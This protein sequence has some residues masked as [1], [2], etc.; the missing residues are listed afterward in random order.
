M[1]AGPACVAF[2]NQFLRTPEPRFDTESY[3]T[4]SVF[5]YFPDLS[6][7]FSNWWQLQDNTPSNVRGHIG[8]P[9]AI[10][11]HIFHPADTSQPSTPFKEK[12]DEPAPPLKLQPKAQ[13]AQRSTTPAEAREEGD[14]E[15]LPQP[16]VPYAPRNADE[17]LDEQ[18]VAISP[19]WSSFD[20][21]KALRNLRSSNQAIIVRQLRILHLRWWHAKSNKMKTILETAGLPKAILD[22]I[23]GVIDTCKVCRLWQRPG[24]SAISSSRLSIEFNHNVQADLLFIGVL[25]I[26]HMICEATRW[27]V[28]VLLEGKKSEHIMPAI[29]NCWFRIWGPPETITA[30][31]EGALCSEEASIAFE[32]WGV[33][34]RPKPVGSHAYVVERHHELLRSQFLHI[35]QQ[36]VVEKLQVSDSEILS[37]ATFAKNTMLQIHGKSPYEAVIGRTPK[38]MQEFEDQ[39]ISAIEDSKGGSLSRHAVRLREV[40][41]QAML[42]GTAQDRVRRAAKTSTRVSAQLKDIQV[43]DTVDIY[44]TPAAKDAIGWRGPATVIGTANIDDGYFDVKWGGRAMSVRV[45]DARRSLVYIAL[46]DTDLTQLRTILDYMTTLHETMQTFA[47]VHDVKGWTMSKAARENPETFRAG[48]YIGTNVFRLRCAGIRI[49]RGVA[50]LR[51]L[52]GLGQCVLMWFPRAEPA[53][54]RTMSFSGTES[55]NFKLVFGNDW[56]TYDW[57]QFLGISEEDSAVIRRIVDD[58]M[59]GEDPYNDPRAPE[60]PR[61]PS[62]R[63]PIIPED[64]NMEDPDM[65]IDDNPPQHPPQPPPQPPQQP[66]RQPP[67][68]PQRL[69]HR[70]QRSRD[71]TPIPSR[72]PVI[73]NASTRQPQPTSTSTMKSAHTDTSADT[74]PTGWKRE[75]RLPGLEPKRRAQPTTTDKAPKPTSQQ[76]GNSAAASSWETPGQTAQPTLLPH[77]VAL[78]I[79]TD[80]DLDTQDSDA[81]R[82]YPDEFYSIPRRNQP[83]LYEGNHSMAGLGEAIKAQQ[84]YLASQIIS[85]GTQQ[86]SSSDIADDEL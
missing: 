8:Y 69:N 3:P 13:R 74:L 2:D 72:E 25:I 43:G 39:G 17:G 75:H 10:L 83:A 49:G 48:L 73:S 33:S 64:D 20:L 9:V 47:M 29:I 78:P 12:P 16:I 40:A 66:P 63:L 80:S 42:E 1:T 46:L 56:E 34:F 52:F 68:Q 36:C 21:G 81:T 59:V 70:Q 50:A 4:R 54:Y 61:V 55:L 60:P 85:S 58:P 82:T 6:T 71:R 7:M 32:R 57:V 15:E 77:E 11:V 37:E 22:L 62:M 53:N 14:E 23:P 44:R 79:D 76:H 27:S 38:I 19:D 65:D 31:H 5:G 35:Q 51:G 26:L 30:D 28:T 86:Q 18:Q 45:A 84:H 41:M 24:R 67:Q